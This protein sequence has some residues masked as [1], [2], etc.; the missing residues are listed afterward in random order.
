M[1]LCPRRTG[2]GPKPAALSSFAA[3]PTTPCPLS[4]R[5][6]LTTS[7]PAVLTCRERTAW[8][9]RVY[10][11]PQWHD[12]SAQ[13]LHTRRQQRPPIVDQRMHAVIG[14]CPRDQ[15]TKRPCRLAL[16]HAAGAQALP[17]MLNRAPAQPLVLPL[18]WLHVPDPCLLS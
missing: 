15:Q 9:R 1:Y 18:L 5:A 7:S 4:R 11:C 16:E 10:C 13:Q 17:Q 8:P 14:S 3:T 2:P 6:I 12:R